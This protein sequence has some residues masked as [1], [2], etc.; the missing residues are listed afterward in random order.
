M[1]ISIALAGSELALV[2]NLSAYTLS[3][4]WIYHYVTSRNGLFANRTAMVL[5]GMASWILPNPFSRLLA[6]SIGTW[7][8]WLA[9][10][11][12]WAKLKG[13]KEMIAEGQSKCLLSS[14]DMDRH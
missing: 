12:N 13:S 7:T 5:G 9:L 4:P 10:L 14:N 6:V 1:L 8:G 2:S 3:T 11:G